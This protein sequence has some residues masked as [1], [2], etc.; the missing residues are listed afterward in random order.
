[1]W[2]EVSRP[3]EDML[4]EIHHQNLCGREEQAERVRGEPV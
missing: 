2:Q 3:S 4:E 1:M